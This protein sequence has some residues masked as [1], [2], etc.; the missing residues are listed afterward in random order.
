MKKSEIDFLKVKERLEYLSETG[1]FLW[2]RLPGNSRTINSWNTQYAGKLAG[3][4]S[5]TNKGSGLYY[6]FIHIGGVRFRAHHLVW[7]FEHG[8]IPEMLDHLDGNGLNNR[9]ENLRELS[10]SDNIRKARVQSNNTSG[11]K[12]VSFRKDTG[13]WTARTKINGKYVS[14]GSFCTKEEAFEIYSQKVLEV[15][16]E[17]HLD[18][19][20]RN[21]A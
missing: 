18:L 8:V 9:I 21:P 17:I 7:L 20:T 3:T 10:M 19:I 16:G 6:R 11:Y 15:A 13:K 14:L 1:E 4:V 5:C 2:K 12:G